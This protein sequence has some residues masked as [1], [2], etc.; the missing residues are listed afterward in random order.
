MP[1]DNI[2]RLLRYDALS[3]A[4]HI[5]GAS[6]HEDEETQLL[7]MHMHLEHQRA[8][9]AVLGEFDDTTFSHDS[10]D[11]LRIVK[12]EGFKEM[13]VEVFTS[14]SSHQM[15]Q[16]YFML[17]EEGVLLIFDTYR[18]MINGGNFYYNWESQLM[19]KD[20]CW[21][22]IID[23]G[24]WHQD[25]D[26][27]GGVWVGYH[28]CREAVR[29]RLRVL[30]EH[31]NF[32]NPWRARP[33]IWPHHHM[34]TKHEYRQLPPSVREEMRAAKLALLPEMVQ[35]V[36]GPEAPKAQNHRGLPAN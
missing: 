7:A 20:E 8:K 24:K 30:R 5:T 26:G 6:H 11:Y 23:N 17:H 21:R 4:E 19:P 36:L 10:E 16:Q 18:G 15:E 2:D 29:H 14:E 22:N 12:E 31:G 27:G 28:N 32:V 13:R 3:E 1:L 9:A 33:L 35:A 25:S 34:E